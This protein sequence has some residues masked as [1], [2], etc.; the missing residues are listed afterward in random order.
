MSATTHG[1]SALYSL[2]E[3]PGSSFTTTRAGF[4][5][6][7]RT[8][9]CWQSVVGTLE[10]LRGSPDSTYFG[11]KV[12]TVEVT[13]DTA[14]V[15][16]LQVSH[17]GIKNQSQTKEDEFQYSV[18][19]ETPVIYAPTF[20]WQASIPKPQV[21]RTFITDKLPTTKIG[22]FDVPLKYAD[23]IPGDTVYYEEAGTTWL[24]TFWFKAWRLIGRTIKTVAG[25]ADLYEI[26]ETHQWD[27]E[28]RYITSI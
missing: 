1:I 8:F 14:G 17:L 28:V 4:D 9:K 10:P 27:F 18:T 12:D 13:F 25:V 26:T 23:M 24:Y 3:Q 15:A 19:D 22:R 2:V 7:R 20:D 6:G 16:T 21:T 5:S 11:M